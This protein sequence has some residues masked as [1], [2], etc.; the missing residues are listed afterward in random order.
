MST[1]ARL[2]SYVE[3]VASPTKFIKVP[4]W[5]VIFGLTGPKVK[6]EQEQIL[7]NR[8]Q[9]EKIE[10]L[11]EHLR[12]HHELAQGRIKGASY[13]N[14][15][16]VFRMETCTVFNVFIPTKGDD[17]K[18]MTLW[19]SADNAAGLDRLFLLQDFHK[20]DE[21]GFGARSAYSSLLLIYQEVLSRA[22]KYD[23]DFVDNLRTEVLREE[24][25]RTERR[26]G[27]SPPAMFGGQPRFDLEPSEGS[28]PERIFEDVDRR[29]KEKLD[30]YFPL[31]DPSDNGVQ[32]R[33]AVDPVS[34]LRD[35]GAQ[36]GGRKDVE[37]LYRVRDVHMETLPE[38]RVATVTF[39][40]PIFVAN[41]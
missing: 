25:K 13:F 10:L 31:L 35:M 2:D 14:H 36:V 17:S 34:V 30:E 40:Y 18:T 28:G 6:G 11:I 33:F 23:Q 3:Q 39:G 19:V 32:R 38:N 41:L 8:T 20:S 29:V 9:S 12:K 21:D 22:Q 15:P 4:K 24:L 16:P 1:V 27:Y 37:T 5:T 26:R 7:Q